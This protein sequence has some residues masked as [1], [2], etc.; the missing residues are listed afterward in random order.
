MNVLFCAEVTLLNIQSPEY[1]SWFL[2]FIIIRRE[3]FH[4]R[5]NWI[6]NFDQPIQLL[7]WSPISP[8]SEMLKR[9][10]QL[11]MNIRHLSNPIFIALV[12]PPVFELSS[13]VISVFIESIHQIWRLYHYY[14]KCLEPLKKYYCMYTFLLY[15]KYSR[16]IM[17]FTRPSATVVQI[18]QKPVEAY[19]CIGSS[20]CTVTSDLSAI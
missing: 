11:R 16:R 10:W 4:W 7:S 3:G 20:L 19:T 14:I 18:I 15:S 2:F 17:A 9:K 8:I 13:F 1:I 12:C 6:H 5:H